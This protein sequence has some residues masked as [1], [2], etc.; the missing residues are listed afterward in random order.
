MLVNNEDVVKICDF[1]WSVNQDEDM[2][3]T[4]CGTYEYMAPEIVENKG[5]DKRVDIWSLG[6]LLYEMLHGYSPFKGSRPMSILE[7]I[8][9]GFYRFDDNVSEDARSLIQMILVVDV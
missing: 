4:F 7:N 2:R 9:K 3:T 5:Y 8:K 6:I 1:G